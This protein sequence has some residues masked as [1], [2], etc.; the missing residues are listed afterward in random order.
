VSA[1]SEQ[2]NEAVSAWLDGECEAPEQ[3]RVEAHLHTCA[4][5]ARL[6]QAY[7]QLGAD[8]R[9]T[10]PTDA[11]PERLRASVERLAS[12]QPAFRPC[13]HTGVVR[14]VAAAAA[15]LLLVLGVLWTGWPR[16]F[17]AALTADLERH[18][19]RAFSRATP[20]EGDAVLL[21]VLGASGR[22]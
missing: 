18:H 5:C 19:L 9:A 6:A 2:W 7:G 17:N 13:W 10:A 1:W 11:L 4:G 14:R 20:C 8:L 15:V 21:G 12:P 16:G 22:P 3:Q